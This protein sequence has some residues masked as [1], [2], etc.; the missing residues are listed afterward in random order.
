[1]KMIREKLAQWNAIRD[2]EEGL[3]TVEYAIVLAL[4]A[5]IAIGAW[6]FLGETV[7]TKASAAASEIAGG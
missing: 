4:V 6:K 2:N 1:M 3:T 7:C 5:V